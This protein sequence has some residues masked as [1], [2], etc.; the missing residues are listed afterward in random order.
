[1]PGIDDYPH[2]T[3]VTTLAHALA[4][5]KFAAAMGIG[6]LSIWA[7]ERDNGGCPGQLGSDTCSGIA[8]PRWAFSHTL[9]PFTRRGR[10]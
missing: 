10:A 4:V 2:K 8:Q 6:T 1:M 7:L 5:R 9:E 3:E